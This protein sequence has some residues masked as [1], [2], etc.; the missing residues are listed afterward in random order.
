MAEGGPGAGGGGAVGKK[1]AGTGV[2]QLHMQADG[3]V[4]TKE[5]RCP[6]QHHDKRRYGPLVTAPDI[7][8]PLPVTG[9]DCKLNSEGTEGSGEALWGR[10]ETTAVGMNLTGFVRGPNLRTV[11]S[12]PVPKDK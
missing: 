2:H 12:D 9:Q 1:W 5:F 4:A 11:D 6:A 7:A 10:V 3:G 8:L